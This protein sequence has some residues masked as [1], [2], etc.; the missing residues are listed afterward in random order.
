M[1]IDTN[2]DLEHA[3]AELAKATKLYEDCDSENRWREYRLL[4]Q[5]LQ[6]RVNKLTAERRLPCGC[7]GKCDP[8]AHDMAWNWDG[9]VDGPNKDDLILRGN[10][11]VDGDAIGKIEEIVEGG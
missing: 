3:Q 8:Y 4:V 5:A 1:N 6:A 10:A 9:K 11:V 2:N 7:I